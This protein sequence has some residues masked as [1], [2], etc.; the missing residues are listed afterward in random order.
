MKF[1]LKREEDP[2]GESK[3]KC[4]QVE[5]LTDSRYESSSRVALKKGV[6][7]P[8]TG[9]HYQGRL[10]QLKYKSKTKSHCVFYLG[11]PH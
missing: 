5:I 8:I 7:S 11:N 6:S 1:K 2:E 9:R 10:R 4:N 3:G